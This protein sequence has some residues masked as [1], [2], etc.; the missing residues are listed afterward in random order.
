MEEERRRGGV[1]N[2]EPEKARSRGD[3]IGGGEI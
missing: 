1:S 3:L 2:D